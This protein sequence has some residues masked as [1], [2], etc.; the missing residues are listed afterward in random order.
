[1]PSNFS[2]FRER[3]RE[4]CRIRNMT[5]TRLC[6][7]V[8]FGGRRAIDLDVHGLRAVDI[9]RLAWIADGLDVSIDWLLGRTNVMNVLEMP[10]L[11]EPPKRKEKKSA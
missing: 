2:V 5:H 7:A 11:S 1:M 9:D 8:G 4:A 3:L 6:S 10:E